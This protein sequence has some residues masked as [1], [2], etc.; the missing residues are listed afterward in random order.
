MKTNSIV[1]CSWACYKVKTGIYI[2]KV[3]TSLEGA[4]GDLRL[5]FKWGCLILLL[6]GKNIW[7]KITECIFKICPECCSLAKEFNSSNFQVLLNS[8]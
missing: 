7:K 1:L 2:L 6:L 4:A 3:R 5:G 8:K